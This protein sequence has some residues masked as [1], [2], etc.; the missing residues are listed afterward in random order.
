MPF[1][2]QPKSP[3]DDVCCEN[4]IDEFCNP[5]NCDL[6]DEDST[7]KGYINRLISNSNT[8]I[9]NVEAVKT[10]HANKKE[11]GLFDL[12]FTESLRKSILEW[13]NKHY[14]RSG[15]CTVCK[16]DLDTFVGLEMAMSLKKGGSIK[17]NWSS[18]PFL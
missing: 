3:D 4:M 18:K 16:D 7:K 6:V 10:T 13:T 9:K 12:F 5:A 2:I 8:T 17:D 14:S 11:V 1:V 15:A